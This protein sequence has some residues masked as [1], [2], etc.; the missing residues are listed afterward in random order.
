MPDIEQLKD[1][2]KKYEELSQEEQRD[3]WAG[4]LLHLAINKEDK[5]N[6]TE[7]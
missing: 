4:V 2:L 5:P 6:A 3:F 1:L 7:R